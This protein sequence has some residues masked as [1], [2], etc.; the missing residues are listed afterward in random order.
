MQELRGQN[1]TGLRR[2]HHPHGLEDPHEPQV[3]RQPGG[4]GGATLLVATLE[5]ARERAEGHGL[6]APAGVVDHGLEHLGSERVVVPLV[7]VETGEGRVVLDDVVAAGVD[8][9]EGPVGPQEGW[10]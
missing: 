2:V 10:E 6:P 3:Q 9:V 4:A 5:G 8:Q 1:P 7:E